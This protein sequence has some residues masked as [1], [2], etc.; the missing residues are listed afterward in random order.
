MRKLMTLGLLAATAGALASLPANA[1]EF[2]IGG[3]VTAE[4]L[5]I[6]ASYLVGIEMAP[7]MQNMVMGDKDVVHLETDVHAKED[8]P[9]GYPTD[10]WIPY[11]KISYKLTKDGTPWNSSGTLLPMTAK[12]GPHYA[13]NVRMNGPGHYKVEL[14]YAS[15]EANGF[16]H[17]IDTETGVPG[18][19]TKPIVETFSFDYPQK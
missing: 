1:R 16:Y 7:M 18:F 2:P 10:A 11:L 5:E 14:T 8:N 3:P 6:A 17:H 12:D 9:W 4:H 13:K 19:W 15:P